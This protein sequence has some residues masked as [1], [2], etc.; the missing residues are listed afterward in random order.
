MN[1][2]KERMIGVVGYLEGEVEDIRFRMASLRREL[3][4]TESELV[5]RKER[6]LK[7]REA[8][9]KYTQSLPTREVTSREYEI[10]RMLNI[11]LKEGEPLSDDTWTA[12]CSHRSK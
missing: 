9:H 4:K 8:L 3:I 7:A 12:V 10:S 2:E 11:H 6:L 1:N 5:G